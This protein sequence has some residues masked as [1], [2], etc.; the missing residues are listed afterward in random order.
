MKRWLRVM[1]I[2]GACLCLSPKVH[3]QGPVGPPPPTSAKPDPGLDVHEL[4]PD[5]G[6]IGAEVGVFAG[7]S[8]NPY[9]AGTGVTGGGFIDLPLSRVPRATRS[10]PRTP[11][12]TWPIWP[13]GRAQPPPSPVPLRPLSP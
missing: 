8:F 1:G 7:A 9:G 13:P 3:A 6:R 2:A 4:L 12:P 5:I 10:P 11:S